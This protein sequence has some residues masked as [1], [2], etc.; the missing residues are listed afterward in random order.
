MKQ[1]IKPL[2]VLSFMVMCSG[3]V[4]GVN[5]GMAVL[6]FA[7]LVVTGFA[8]VY[9]LGSEDREY[10][11]QLE[12]IRLEHAKAVDLSNQ[13]L[14]KYEELELRVSKALSENRDLTARL[15]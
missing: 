2:I 14:A 15:R 7:A 8:G 12:L 3:L 1:L 6:G 13:R 10:Q 11:Q 9:L 4:P 5:I